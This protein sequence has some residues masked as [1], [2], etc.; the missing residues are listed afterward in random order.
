MF[1][2]LN[3]KWGIPDDY[4]VMGSS[5]ATVVIRQWQWMPG[6]VIMSQLC[7][8]GMEATMFA[9]LAGCSNVGSQV[10]D[11][12]GAYLLS[13]LHVHPSGATGEAKQFENLWK[14]SLISTLL[15]AITILMIPVFIPNARQTD[16]LL[17]EESTSATTGSLWSRWQAW[18]SERST[19]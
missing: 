13:S 8:K 1:L 19:V 18:R 10:S 7:P 14:A 4:F 5:V 12:M 11:Y 9:L 17:N 16:K 2:R 15:P 3:L 6:V